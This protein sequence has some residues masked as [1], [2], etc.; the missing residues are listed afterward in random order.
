LV[1]KEYLIVK[2]IILYFLL[3]IITTLT[4]LYIYF[5]SDYVNTK[6][7]KN[8]I[9]MNLKVVIKNEVELIASNNYG[10]SEEGG[11]RAL[12]KFKDK[13]CQTILNAMT[14]NEKVSK[15]SMYYQMFNK[16]NIDSKF[17]K[18]WYHRNKLG[19]FTKYAFDSNKC[20][21]F[22]QYHYE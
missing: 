6:R 22:R 7:L 15:T 4:S 8:Q 18:S 17:V 11:D 19:D 9:Q 12:L 1:D 3:A 14:N 2:K 20:I 13:D 16:Y 10:W 5:T 21:L